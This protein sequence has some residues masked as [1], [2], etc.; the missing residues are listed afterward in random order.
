MQWLNDVNIYHY[1]IDKSCAGRVPESVMIA[2]SAT[3]DDD[4]LSGWSCP[5]STTMQST[6]VNFPLT[7]SAGSSKTTSLITINLSKLLQP[8]F[9]Y[10]VWV[11]LGNHAGDVTTDNYVPFSELAHSVVDMYKHLL[12]Y[13]Y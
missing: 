12:L 2:E 8:N 7:E 4:T 3:E 9:H 6:C 10:K 11:I 1:Q 13:I 5:L